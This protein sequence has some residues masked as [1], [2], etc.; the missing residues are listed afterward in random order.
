[1][2]DDEDRPLPRSADG[3]LATGQRA[4]EK[5]D[6]AEAEAAFQEVRSDRPERWEGHLGVARVRALRS[7]VTGA[8]LHAQD[9]IRADHACVPA[10]QL[11]AQIGFHGGVADVAIEWLE[12]GA[13]EL[14]TEALLFEWLVRLYAV[15]GR[16]DDLRACLAHYA[17][18]RGRSLGDA[19]LLFARD[20]TTSEDVRSRIVAAS[21]G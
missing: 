11:L 13:Q 4:L 1:M 9:A 15:E 14:P 6:L 21:R 18:L 16:L 12:H 5:G 2:S 20:P 3:L 8:F 10:Y 19:A 7:D 17:Q